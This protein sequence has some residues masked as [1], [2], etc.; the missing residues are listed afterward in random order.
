MYIV[1]QCRYAKQNSVISFI[2]ELVFFKLK[3]LAPIAIV[4][5]PH[6]IIQHLAYVISTTKKYN[7]VNQNQKGADSKNHTHQPPTL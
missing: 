6:I 2:R 5:I 3:V 7:A 4:S 1:Q